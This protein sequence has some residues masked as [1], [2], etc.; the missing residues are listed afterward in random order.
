MRQ[1]AILC[2]PWCKRDCSSLLSCDYA[3][4]IR[5]VNDKARNETK[6]CINTLKKTLAALTC[7]KLLFSIYQTKH[8]VM[9]E[10]IVN[11]EIRYTNVDI[12]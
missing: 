10:T 1:L 11:Q 9:K 8:D 6:Y 3:A 2:Q 7:M 12:K 4:I 5:G